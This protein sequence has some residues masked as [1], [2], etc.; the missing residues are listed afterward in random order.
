L[1]RRAISMSIFF[2]VFLGAFSLVN[3]YIFLRGW[4]ALTVPSAC[5]MSVWIGAHLAA[6][7]LAY[8]CAFIFC[9]CSF[10]VGRF[11]ERAFVNPFTGIFV[12]VGSYWFAAMLYF[13]FAV[14]GADII[15]LLLYIIPGMPAAFTDALHTESPLIAM[16]VIALITMVVAVGHF[17]ARTIR[18]KELQIDIPK[19]GRGKKEWNIVAASDIHLGTIISKPRLEKIVA[20]INSLN[21]DLILL[22]GDVFDEDL[23][24]VI[25]KNLGETLRLLKAKYGVYAVTGN[26]EYIGGVEAAVRYM[27]EHGIKVLRDE[28]VTIADSLVLVGR[29]DL[30]AKM[31]DGTRRKELSEIMKD[32]DR[33]FPIILM[34]HQPYKLEQA[35]ENGVDVQLSGH[36]HNG[37]LWPLNYLTRS[38]YEVSWGYKKKENTHVYVSCG[39]G[40]WGPPVKLGNVS[41]VIRL[42]VRVN[43]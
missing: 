11:L 25:S 24:P 8:V 5:P 37:Q 39:V 10:L 42:R 30:S 29:E 14:A 34:D 43:G 16:T 20:K 35:V 9:S 40:T 4:E 19:N 1:S 13:F 3:Y 2:A 12:W 36:T 23:G 33:S 32:V 27:R 15:R 17:N 31:I 22:P 7:H 28:H 6:A 38:I 21:P 41:E 18:V 26:H